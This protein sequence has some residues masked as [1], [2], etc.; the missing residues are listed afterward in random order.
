MRYSDEKIKS[1]WGFIN[2]IWNASRYVLMSLGEDYSRE[3]I[4]LNNLS[5]FDK[6]ILNRLNEKNF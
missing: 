1:S 3:D 5:L 4:D 2:K 6:W